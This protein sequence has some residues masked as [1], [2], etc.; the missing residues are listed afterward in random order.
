MQLNISRGPKATGKTV[1]LRQTAMKAGIKEKNILIGT[2][3][4]DRELEA[5]VL[6]LALRGLKVICIDECREEQL[7]FLRRVKD[8]ICN[9]V[10]VHVV[11]AN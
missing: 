8:R 9:S 5:K 11:V 3:Y 6:Q 7:A 1:R 10:T 4:P 2:S